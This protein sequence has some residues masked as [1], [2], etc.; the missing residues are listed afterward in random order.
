[1]PEVEDY[2]QKAGH[3]LDEARQIAGIGLATAAARS[4]YYAAFHTG[5]LL[6]SQQCTQVHAQRGG[7]RLVQLPGHLQ[8]VARLVLLQRGGAVRPPHPV[9]GT[10]IGSGAVQT[11]L[12][13]LNSG[14]RHWLDI[15]QRQDGLRDR[16]RG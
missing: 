3:V 15:G 14:W 7:S 6:C 4:A 10:V 8:L 1:M 12:H 2:L 16:C 5:R 13:L 9:Y 11:L